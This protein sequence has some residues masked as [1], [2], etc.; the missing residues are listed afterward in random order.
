METAAGD[1]GAMSMR[2]NLTAMLLAAGTF[3]LGGCSTSALLPRETAANST[4]F[5]TYNDVEAAYAAV[6]PGTTRTPDLARLGFD[7]GSTPN[8]DILSYPGIT[9]RFLPQDTKSLDHVPPQVRACIEAQTRCTAYVFHPQRFEIHHIG[10][11]L[12]DV[13]GFEQ[14][15]VRTGWSAD[16]MLVLLDGVVVYKIMSGRPLVED[17]RD[18][19]QPLGLLQSIGSTG[20]AAPADPKRNKKDK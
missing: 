20:N 7:A 5:K 19:I 15:V 9:A 4:A 1:I 3:A 13:T 17:A 11:T 2:R 18:S 10:N 6:Q 16:V 14:K 12:L 8:V